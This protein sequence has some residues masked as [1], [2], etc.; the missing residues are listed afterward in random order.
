MSTA[1]DNGHYIQDL[2]KVRKVDPTHVLELELPTGSFYITGADL[3][4]DISNYINATSTIQGLVD[5]VQELHGIIN[6]PRAR[7]EALENK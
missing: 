7:I 2:T 3:Y 4:N 5:S 1:T 6:G